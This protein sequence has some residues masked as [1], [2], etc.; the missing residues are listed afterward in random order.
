MAL[1]FLFLPLI[2]ITGFA[3]VDAD[4]VARGDGPFEVDA[5]TDVV[6]ICS[7]LPEQTCTV[8]VGGHANLK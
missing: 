8:L 7:E 2:F 5:E 4:R 1:T 6:V 3:D